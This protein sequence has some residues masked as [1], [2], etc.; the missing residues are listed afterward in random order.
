MGLRKLDTTGMWKV[1]ASPIYVP[2]TDVGVEYNSL[3][4]EDSGRD[5][6]GYM[7]I[8]WVRTDL[9]KVKLKYALMTG[10]ELAYM[11]NL[12]QGKEFNFT[13]A[14]ETGPKTFEGYTSKIDATLYTQMGNTLIYKD[15]SIN[16]I[17]K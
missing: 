11:R 9:R 5:E 2:D 12:M 8:I 1:N 16:V 15:V 14:D 3:A 6:S 4:S 17:E 13:Y 7:H 10:D